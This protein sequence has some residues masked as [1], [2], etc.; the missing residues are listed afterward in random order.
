MQP[1]ESFSIPVPHHDGG[2][3]RLLTAHQG[4]IHTSIFAVHPARFT[5]LRSKMAQLNPNID[6]FDPELPA[7]LLDAGEATSRRFP[8]P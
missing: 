4:M 6:S 5:R 8:N 7:D 1:I 2:I 3:M